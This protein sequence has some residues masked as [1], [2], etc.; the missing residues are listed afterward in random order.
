MFVR[1]RE[2]P[3]AFVTKIGVVQYFATGVQSQ[4]GVEAQAIMA[5]GLLTSASVIL[6]TVHLPKA[7]GGLWRRLATYAC[8]ATLLVSFGWQMAMLK[9]KLDGKYPFHLIF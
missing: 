4:Y 3:A 5:L 2:S 9:F 6:L 1:I 8:C 7:K